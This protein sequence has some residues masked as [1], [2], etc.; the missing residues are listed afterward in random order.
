MQQNQGVQN[1]IQE[2]ERTKAMLL[3]Q[4]GIQQRLASLRVATEPANSGLRQPETDAERLQRLRGHLE[5]LQGKYT[6]SHPDVVRTKQQIVQLEGRV[7]KGDTGVKPSGGGGSRS[8][9][10][11][12]L[13]GQRIQAQIKQI[14]TNIAQLREQQ[15]KIPPQIEKHQAW[16]EAVPTREAE[17]TGLTRDYTELRRHYDQLVAQNLQAQSVENLERSQKG[18]KF[19]I[20]DSARLPEKPF[21]PNFMKMLLV[22]VG[23][24]LSLSLGTIML[25]DF[26]DTSFKDVAEVEDFIGVPVICAIPFIEKEAETRKEKRLYR[27]S[28]AIIALYGVILLATIMVMGLKGLIIV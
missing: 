11:A 15:A 8:A 18:S 21:K 4:S 5:E 6:A 25:L 19:K 9:M 10:V 23:V 7:G 3:E 1:S 17:W 14:D 12:S 22:A 24:G 26:V 20:V 27:I 28:V 13:E 2:L 16:I